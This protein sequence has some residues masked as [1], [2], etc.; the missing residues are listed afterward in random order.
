MK[1]IIFIVLIGIFSSCCSN[2]E[3]VDELCGCERTEYYYEWRYNGTDRVRVKFFG[4]KNI[5]VD[6]Q[7]EVK[8]GLGRLQGN[9]RWYYDI[10]CN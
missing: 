5:P 6:C 2:K 3:E 4:D 10:S 8:S 9:R 7:D 1:K